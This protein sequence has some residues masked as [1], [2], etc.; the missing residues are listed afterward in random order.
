MEQ[1]V[2][3]AATALVH[4]QHG[5]AVS[6]EVGVARLVA[7]CRAVAL[8]VGDVLEDRRDRVA[9]GVLWQP[10]AR[11]KARAVRERDPRVV[12]RAHGARQVGYDPHRRAGAPS[13]SSACS[14][15]AGAGRAHAAAAPSTLKGLPSNRTG[16]TPRCSTVWTR[17]FARTCASSKSWPRLRTSLAGTRRAPSAATASRTL[18]AGEAVLHAGDVSCPPLVFPGVSGLGLRVVGERVLEPEQLADLA[19]LAG[20]EARQRDEAVGAGVGAVVGVERLKGVGAGR[21]RLKLGAA[22]RAR[23]R[24][25]V[26]ALGGGVAVE[27]LDLHEALRLQRQRRTEERHLEVGRALAA[28]EQARGHRERREEPCGEVSERQ[29]AGP[30][31]HRVAWARV[32]EQEAGERLPDQVIRRAVR[33]RAGASEGR[34]ADGHA[35]RVHRADAL[36]VEPETPGT[37]GQAVVHERVGGCDQGATTL[38][39][40]G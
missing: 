12:D 26:G 14:P 36:R 23:A 2:R 28:A 39:P 22:G 20:V 27:R 15:S 32:G 3:L 37:L 5:V 31:R 16:P 6:R 33:V 35:A 1:A 13:S 40:P 18:E 24:R 25:R 19:A 38:A 17:P 29:P 10:D 8:P 30:A 4:T 34:D 11:A 7:R 21:E 9:L